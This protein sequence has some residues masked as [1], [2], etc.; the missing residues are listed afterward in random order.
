[1]LAG[2]TVPTCFGEAATI[3]GTAGDDLLL[4]TEGDD[5]IVGLRGVDRLGGMEG[6]DVMCGGHGPDAVSGDFDCSVRM[7]DD[8]LSGGR[9][10]DLVMGD[11]CIAQ[12]DDPGGA[13]VV[14]GDRGDDDVIGGPADDTVDGGSGTDV[15]VIFSISAARVDLAT[16]TTGGAEGVDSI[17]LGSVENVIPASCGARADHSIIGDDRA[18]LLVSTDGRD[19]IEGRGGDDRIYTWKALGPSPCD[20]EEDQ[21]D[22]AFG[23]SGDD[24]LVTGDGND[25]LDGGPGTDRGRGGPDTDTCTSIE[26]RKACELSP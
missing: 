21:P 16:G 4:G 22:R 15:F 5:V 17:A 3:V 11:G 8:Q 13:D 6:N 9:G 26:K 14:R 18:N 25:L 10:N 2:E 12:P 19:E 20:H 7:G 23:G 1:M 24:L